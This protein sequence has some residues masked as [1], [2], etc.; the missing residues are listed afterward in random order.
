VKAEEV[1]TAVQLEADALDLVVGPV[2]QDGGWVKVFLTTAHA[3]GGTAIIESDGVERFSLHMEEFHW[4]E[5]AHE[6][7]D[8]HEVIRDLARLAATHLFGHTKVRTE[9]RRWRSDRIGLEVPWDGRT[10]L[11]TKRGIKPI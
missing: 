3:S 5:F 10:Y 11:V 8:Q 2:V 6:E 9:R 7:Q 1:V 4:P